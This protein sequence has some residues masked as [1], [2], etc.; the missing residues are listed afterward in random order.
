MTEAILKKEKTKNK[1]VM[2]GFGVMLLKKNKILLGMRHPDPSK[3]DSE[4]HG[5]GTWSMPGG[6]IDF[7]ESFEDVCYREV[8]E[9]TGI[10]IDKKSLKLVSL[11]NDIGTDAHFVTIGF[12]SKKFKG[13]PKLMEPDEWVCWKWI[14]YNKLPN[15]MFFPSVELLNNYLN[16]TIYKA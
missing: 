13:K 11:A 9:E 4:L 7:G 14:N 12:L 5:E 8:L 10:K 3:A 1:T 6:K 15:K 2:V 16:H